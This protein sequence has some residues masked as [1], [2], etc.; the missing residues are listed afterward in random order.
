V[1]QGSIEVVVVV[2][3]VEVDEEEV[4][5]VDGAVRVM[6]ALIQVSLRGGVG[7]PKK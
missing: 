7:P 2:V 3:V 4:I 6:V 1:G 5:V